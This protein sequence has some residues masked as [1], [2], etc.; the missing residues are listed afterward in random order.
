MVVPYHRTEFNQAQLVKADTHPPR[1]REGRP[2]DLRVLSRSRV[3]SALQDKAMKE[4]LAV[5]LQHLSSATARYERQ[6]RGLLG[7]AL[8]LHATRGKREK[9]T[10]SCYMKTASTQTQGETKPETLSNMNMKWESSLLKHLSKR[11]LYFIRVNL[12]R[13]SS[14]N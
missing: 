8:Y 5:I 6:G 1:S 12:Q 10:V 2:C 3:P 7:S 11:H 13:R 14:G 4:S 9:R